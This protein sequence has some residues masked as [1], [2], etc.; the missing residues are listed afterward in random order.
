MAGLNND[1]VP[2]ELVTPPF[3]WAKETPFVLKY[4]KTD[5]TVSS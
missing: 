5:F 3:N 4:I 2:L 1:K